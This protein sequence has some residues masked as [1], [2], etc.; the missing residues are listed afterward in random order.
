MRYYAVIPSFVL[1]A[2]TLC[3]AQETLLDRGYREMYNLQFARAHDC[4]QEWARLYPQ[5][6]MGPA[7]DAAAYLFSEFGRLHILEA[8][9]FTHDRHF[10]TD[11]KLVPDAEV[12]RKFDGALASARKLAGDAPVES[13][14]ALAAILARGLRSDYMALIEKRYA[15]AF[16]EMKASR[17]MAERLLAAHPQLYDAWIAVGVENYMLSLKPAP[18]RWLLQLGGAQT[19]RATG[20]AKLRLTAE[21]GHY[22]APF[23]RLLLAV[24]ALRDG[25]TGSARSILEALNREYPQN[26]LYARELA[27]LTPI[28]LRS[29]PQ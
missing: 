12:K 27:L 10:M 5:D 11:H 9:F 6:P 28:A 8:E 25:D 18:L 1:C 24:A 21:K 3:P 22:L 13:N 7:S 19:D 2:A 4:F 29:A 15:A 26:P 20:L 14:A 16:R 23:A 17:V